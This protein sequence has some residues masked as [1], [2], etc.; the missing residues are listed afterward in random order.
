[1]LV[2]IIVMNWSGFQFC[3]VPKA[4]DSSK[5]EGSQ[6]FCSTLRLS[7]TSA[8]ACHRGALSSSACPPTA[9][10]CLFSGPRL[11]VRAIGLL[12]FF[13]SNL[14]LRPAS[15]KMGL[16]QC[17]CHFC[18]IFSCIC[19]SSIIKYHC[20]SKSESLEITSPFAG[21]PHWEIWC[22]T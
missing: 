4:T 5:P 19:G 21:S 17:S 18:Q 2:P 10:D 20:P 7:T 3:S 14:S 16:S 11:I 12:K 22:G 1:M 15:V 9:E 6:Y 13:W 8:H